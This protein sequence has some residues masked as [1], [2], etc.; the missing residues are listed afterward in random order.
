MRVADVMTPKPVA[1][2]PGDTVHRALKTMA[3]HGISGCP[4]TSRGK[5]V[6]ILSQS[7]VVALVDVHAGIQRGTAPLLLASLLT[8]KYD[9]L[10]PALRA[11]LKAPVR[12]HMQQDVIT[13]DAD[14]D[15]Y[16]A[17]KLMN[18]HNIERLPVIDGDRLV[19]IVSKTDVARLLGKL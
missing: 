4:V 5:L 18:K 16:D 1:L 13:V 10:K 19:G 9:G 11:V 3:K 8:Q 2:K 15:V 12:K 17:V 6:G 14:A 7:D